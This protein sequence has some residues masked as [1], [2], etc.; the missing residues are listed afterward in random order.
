MATLAVVLTVLAL[1]TKFC[2]VADL[3]MYVAQESD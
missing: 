3:L 2:L 1:I